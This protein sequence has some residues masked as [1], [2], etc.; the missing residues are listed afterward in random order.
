MPTIEHVKNDPVG[1]LILCKDTY[2]AI[3]RADREADIRL[4][5]ACFV[6]MDEFDR[7]PTAWRKFVK[8]INETSGKKRK[9]KPDK[10]FDRKNTIIAQ[11]VFGFKKSYDRSYKVARVLDFVRL[12]STDPQV[13]RSKIKEAGGIEKLYNEAVRTLPYLGKDRDIKQKMRMAYAAGNRVALAELAGTKSTVFDGLNDGT[14]VQEDTGES[15]CPPEEFVVEVTRKQ[16]FKLISKGRGKRQRLIIEAVG[17]REDGWKRFKL[18]SSEPAELP[19]DPEDN[20]IS[21]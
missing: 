12:T 14:S 6:A 21:F 19:L 16:F 18:I 5:Q 9:I 4:F 3:E 20:E 7:Q 8:H 13:L 15:D 1:A 11:F 10:S 17:E 2:V